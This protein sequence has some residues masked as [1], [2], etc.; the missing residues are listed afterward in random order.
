MNAVLDGIRTQS[1][2]IDDF[3]YFFLQLRKPRIRTVVERT[4]KLHPEM[5]REQ[6]AQ[7]LIDSTAN[8]TL[9]AGSLL[10][11]PLMLPGVHAFLRYFGLAAGSAVITRMH[12]YLI[13]EIALLYD[14]DID[15]PERVSEMMA[16]V[17]ATEAGVTLPPIA[18]GLLDVAPV[19]SMA[20]SAMTS[21]ALTR[22]IGR[23]AMNFY[24]EQTSAGSRRIATADA[25]ESISPTA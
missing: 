11:M 7:R 16:V 18:L 12:L 24:E 8:L 19:V 6:I 25:P 14:K 9:V 17:A 3:F 15:D 20:T 5:T 23:L 21:T 22:V 1:L 2:T 10:G 13:L 4:R